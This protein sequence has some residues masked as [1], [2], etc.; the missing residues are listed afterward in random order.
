M[1]GENSAILWK[2]RNEWQQVE[3][4]SML[5]WVRVK[6]FSCKLRLGAHFL[7]SCNPAVPAFGSR[8]CRTV[9]TQVSSKPLKVDI[10]KRS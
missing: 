7:A 4:I 9:F 6:C 3:I 8:I 2:N 1:L 5:I 10:N